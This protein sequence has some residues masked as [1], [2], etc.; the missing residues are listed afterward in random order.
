[1]KYLLTILF[2]IVA[3]FNEAYATTLREIE[4]V[5][6]LKL[7]QQKSSSA[8]NIVL[9]YSNRKKFLSK[10]GFEP[11][12]VIDSILKSKSITNFNN[13][14]VRIE[15]VDSIYTY[16]YYDFSAKNNK[17]TPYILIDNKIKHKM[18]DTLVF[19]A[20]KNTTNNTSVDFSGLDQAISNL[21]TVKIYS[22]LPAQKNIKQQID[23][24][25]NKNML[26]FP[27]DIDISRWAINMTKMKIYII[28]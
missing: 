24:V 27:A 5:D 21:H 28:E 19:H 18:G 6:L 26:I 14:I 10:L 9:H 2:F 13:V 23:K 15:T 20:K 17:I 16:T 1:M 11:H 12:Q 7:A 8:K 22:Q 3:L 4:E 25:F